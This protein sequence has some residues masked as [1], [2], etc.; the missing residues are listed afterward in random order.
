MFSGMPSFLINIDYPMSITTKLGRW[1]VNIVPYPANLIFL[2]LAG[3][4]LL[5]YMLGFQRWLCVLGA[6][7]YTFASYNIINI[8]AGHSSKVIALGFAP[9]LIASVLLAYRGKVLLGSALAGFFAGLEL[10]ANHVQITY[11]I[12]LTLLLFVIYELI[13]IIIHKESLLTFTKASLLLALAGLL[14]AGS[15]ASRLWTTYDY[16]AQTIRGK[17][18]L[19]TNKQST[20][21]AL[22]RNYAFQWSYGI[23]ETFTLLIPNFYGGGTGSGAEQGKN[24]QSMKVLQENG[25]DTQTATNYVRGFPYYWGAQPFTSGPAYLG[26]IVCLLFVFGLL[27][28]TNPMKWWLLASTILMIMIAWGSNFSTLN[29]LLFDYLPMFNKFRAHTMTLSV[30]Q[31]FVA[32]MALLGLQEL[33]NPNLDKK[34]ALKHLKISAGIVG[35]LCLFI[36][37]LGGGVQ[38]FRSLGTTEITDKDGKKTEIGNDEAF[39]QSITQGTQGNQEFAKRLL[40]AIEDDRSAMQSRDAIRSLIFI[41]LATGLMWTLFAFELPLMYA[42]GGLALLILIDLWGIDRRYLNNDNFVKKSQFEAR[43]E[44][45]DADRQ[46]LQDKSKFRVAN[47]TKSIFN[48]ATTSYHHASI[49]GYHAA[50]LRRYQDLIDSCLSRNNIPVYSMLNTKYFLVGNE[51]QEI[52]AQRNEG[53]CGNAWFVEEY[54]IVANADEEIKSLAKFNPQKTAFIDR[55]FAK[56]LQGLNIKVDSNSTIRLLSAKPDE[57]KYE[58]NASSPQLAVFSEIYFVQAGKMAWQASIDGKPV[59]HLR[60]NYVLRAI[61]VPAGKHTITFKFDSPSFHSGE[62]IAL[63]CSVI[64]LAMVG[65]AIWAYFRGLQAKE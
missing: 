12:F 42:V 62:W 54:K 48:D 4:Y 21:G 45:T 36:A 7:A 61:P 9:P 40:R 6:I 47:F 19:S 5:A 28:S 14:A 35:G 59:E 1:I 46:I 60:A 64:L 24:S 51:N 30:V 29:Y 41:L 22:D 26:A 39:R 37:V 33:F 18:E 20:S 43:F 3:F 34:L 8:E 65:L 53:A 17:S 55:K 49:G 27:L 11:Y 2:Y 56:Q 44:P 63:I 52:V 23:G 16:T 58:S 38:D 10:Y 32:G 31:L 50:K 25:I 57:L 13:R 15:H